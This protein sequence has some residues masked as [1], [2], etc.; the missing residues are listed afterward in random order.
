[1]AEVYEIC[2][3]LVK[4]HGEIQMGKH[5]SYESSPDK[6]FFLKVNKKAAR[7]TNSSVPGISPGE[8]LNMRSECIDQLEK[9]HHLM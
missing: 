8:G 6:H 4:G 1:M 9:W 3:T 5:D 2:D 7:A